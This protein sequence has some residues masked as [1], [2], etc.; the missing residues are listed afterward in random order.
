METPLDGHSYGAVG[1]HRAESIAP[2]QKKPTT[3]TSTT[4]HAD[5]TRQNQ[6]RRKMFFLIFMAAIGGF[7]FGYD[8]GVIS[9]AMLP[10]QQAFQLTKVQEETIVSSTVFAALVSSFLG[11]HWAGKYGRKKCILLAAALFTL[12]AL[13]LA[14]A[15]TYVVLVLGRLVV[16]FGIGL[17]SLTTP[18]YI[19]EVSLASMRGQLVVV[20]ILFIALGE[21]IAGMVDG[22]CITLLPSNGW[23]YMLGIA[24]IPGAIMFIGFWTLPE[25]PRW[26]VFDQRPEEAYQVLRTLRD[27]DEEARKET[28][29]IVQILLQERPMSFR[30]GLVAVL[31]DAPTRRALVLGCGMQLLQQ[32]NGINTVMVS[33]CVCVGGRNTMCLV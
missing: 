11:G 16:G 13:L 18:I 17:T 5:K 6:V 19:A 3:T 12:G 9:G 24:A 8:T 26:L 10:I 25:S 14:F 20:N 31:S 7:L 22:V 2:E 32:L 33:V 1:I 21:F 15:W 29:D 27:T 23:R 4:L 28:N 30:E